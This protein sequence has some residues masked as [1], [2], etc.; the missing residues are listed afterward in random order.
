[1]RS[2]LRAI[3]LLTPD[4]ISKAERRDKHGKP[5]EPSEFE[6]NHIRKDKAK[7]KVIRSRLSD[8][9]WWMRL[10]SQHIA[11]RANKEDG[12]VGKFWNL[13]LS[14]V[15]SPCLT[16]CDFAVAAWPQF[17][18]PSGLYPIGFKLRKNV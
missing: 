8:I 6:L 9:S 17:N 3:W 4:P 13:P 16:K 1:M 18:P 7:L 15:S 12:E 2:T 11:Q 14:C 10:L 5:E